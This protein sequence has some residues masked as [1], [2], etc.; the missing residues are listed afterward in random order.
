MT[1][2]RGRA[3][4]TISMAVGQRHILTGSGADRIYFETALSATSNVDTISTGPSGDEDR[5]VLDRAIFTALAPGET[6]SASAFRTGTTA[7]RCGRPDHFNPANSALSYDADGSGAQAA[8]QFADLQG[9]TS[10]S[11]AQFIIIG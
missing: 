1:R 8:I 3:A 11:A 10:F 5:L 7:P 4:T 6:L 9:M 2:W